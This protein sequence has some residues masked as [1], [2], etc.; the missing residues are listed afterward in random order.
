[1]GASRRVASLRHRVASLHGCVA[2]RRCVIASRRVAASV[3]HRVASLHGRVASLRG[4]VFV[5]ARG[6]VGASR[7]CVGTSVRGRGPSRP[8]DRVGASARRVAAWAGP[9]TSLGSSLRRCI[10]SLCGRVAGR[11]GPMVWP[12]GARARQIPARLRGVAWMRVRVAG[13]V[14]RW[15]VRVRVAAWVSR[16]RWARWSVA[17]PSCRCV[18]GALRRCVRVSC[19]R[20]VAW[21]VRLDSHPY[22]QFLRHASHWLLSDWHADVSQP[23]LGRR[24]RVCC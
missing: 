15:L 17:G 24:C 22:A 8:R 13:C 10:A 18:L 23:R 2:S 19:G 14:G 12:V 16:C 3:R 1:M 21:H 5:L 6:R 4:R 20:A 7:R 11:V 9:I